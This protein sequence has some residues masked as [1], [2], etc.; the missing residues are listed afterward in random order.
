M[1]NYKDPKYYE[2]KK[3]V[4]ER[5]DKI[6]G[7]P[8][9]EKYS[10]LIYARIEEMEKIHNGGYYSEGIFKIEVET[11]DGEIDFFVKKIGRDEERKNTAGEEIGERAKKYITG[12]QKVK[13]AGLPTFDEAFVLDGRYFITTLL[14][15]DKK[16]VIS[17]NS[18]DNFPLDNHALRYRKIFKNQLVVKNFK[19][20]VAGIIEALIA[21]IN[22]DIGCDTIFFLV[23][24]DHSGTEVQIEWLV[25]DY[26]DVSGDANK[27]MSILNSQIGAFEGNMMEFILAYCQFQHIDEYMDILKRETEDVRRKYIKQLMY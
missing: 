12:Y 10:A 25:G 3:P 21:A 27:N 5:Y 4:N 9:N 22:I 6:L 26:D 8:V 19:E 16:A 18:A 2:N 24:V 11:E 13:E 17:T 15:K 23:P 1:E 20:L 7:A 14:N